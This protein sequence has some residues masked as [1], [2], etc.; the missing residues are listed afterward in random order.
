M[1]L[2]RLLAVSLLAA[3]ALAP[4]AAG[5]GVPPAARRLHVTVVR[6]GQTTWSGSFTS[7][8]KVRHTAVLLDALEPVPSGTMTCDLDSGIRVRMTF[9]ARSGGPALAEAVL[10]PRGCGPVTMRVGDHSR[11]PLQ[12]SQALLAWLHKLGARWG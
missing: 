2:A 11:P 12:R 5:D 6:A 1:A 3:A 10:D 4:S 9:T 7:R 8:A